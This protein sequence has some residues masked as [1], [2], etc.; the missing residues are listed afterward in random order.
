MNQAGVIETVNEVNLIDSDD[1]GKQCDDADVDF[2]EPRRHKQRKTIVSPD[3]CKVLDR[4][5]A[6]DRQATRILAASAKTLGYY[7]NDC[8]LSSST[9][10]RHRIANRVK[11]AD[12][13]KH[14]FNPSN[15]LVVHW[16]GKLLPDLT[17]GGDGKLNITLLGFL[18]YLL[19]S[20]KPCFYFVRVKRLTTCR[21]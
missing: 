16:D 14:D 9:V 5:G 19:V 11:C 6:S 8:S 21:F 18:L 20:V 7:L 1:N 15:H 3:V 2:A 12:Q 10:R 4:C 13:I 17:D